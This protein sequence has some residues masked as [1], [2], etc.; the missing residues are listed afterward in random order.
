M[1]QPAK[2]PIA[3][4]GTGCRFPGD[5]STP[6]R[7]WNLLREPRDLS[8]PLTDRFDPK[9]WY[10]SNGKYHGHA[11]VQNSYQLADQGC[12]RRFDAQFFG[13][14]PVEASTMDPQIRLLLETV[15]EAVEAAG[16]TIESLRGSDTAFYTGVSRHFFLIRLIKSARDHPYGEEKAQCVHVLMYKPQ[17][18]IGDY[19][20]GMERD[21][22][23]IGTYHVSGVSRAM[24]ANRLSYFFD[25]RGPSMC[26]HLGYHPLTHYSLSVRC[27]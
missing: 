4:I 16:Q 21:V 20:I 5:S 8:N 3:I 25:W 14:S 11:N 1:M 13:I 23:S 12:Q 9:G 19:K 6:S 27:P 24:M 26:V 7:L 17:M 18:M 10:H 22:D 15:Y 2:E